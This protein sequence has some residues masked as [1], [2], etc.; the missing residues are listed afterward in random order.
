M[1]YYICA[2]LH[3]RTSTIT[4]N[5]QRS[6]AQT[7]LSICPS[8]C[9]ST[10]L[11]ICPSYSSIFPLRELCNQNIQRKC[12]A[13]IVRGIPSSAFRF[14]ALGFSLSAEGALVLSCIFLMTTAASTRPESPSSCRPA[15]RRCSVFPIATNSVISS[16]WDE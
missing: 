13:G 16:T 10:C 8:T 6:L 11:S 12:L 1:S 7:C 2:C 5:L 3:G 9:P 4:T 14:V 15:L